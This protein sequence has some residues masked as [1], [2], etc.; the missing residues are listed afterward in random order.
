MGRSFPTVECRRLP[1][2]VFISCSFDVQRHVRALSLSNE[3]HYFGPTPLAHAYASGDGHGTDRN[4]RPR[5][6]VL[7]GETAVEP[8]R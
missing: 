5:M 6:Y 3:R 2:R 7:E 8:G 4:R 1:L